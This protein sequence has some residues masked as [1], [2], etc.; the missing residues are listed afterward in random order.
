MIN[1]IIE[2]ISTRLKGSHEYNLEITL[3]E[4]LKESC[5]QEDLMEIEKYSGIFRV[6]EYGY[7]SKNEKDENKITLRAKINN[8]N[9]PDRK[10]IHFEDGK[11]DMIIGDLLGERLLQGKYQ[12]KRRESYSAQR[13]APRIAF[14]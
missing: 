6:T 5:S 14:A 9:F 13:S 7:I 3:C 4:K 8:S 2:H 10:I 1:E 11:M 12:T